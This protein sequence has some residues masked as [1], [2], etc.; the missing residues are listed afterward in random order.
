MQNLK[1]RILSVKSDNSQ[2]MMKFLKNSVPNLNCY[3]FGTEIHLI[4]PPEK[5]DSGKIIHFIIEK[6]NIQNCQVRKADPS[7]EDVFME[8]SG[9]QNE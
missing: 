7:F 4:L 8:S 1:N 9:G 6:S 5:E 2:E 3:H